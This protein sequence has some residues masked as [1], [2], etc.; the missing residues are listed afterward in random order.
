FVSQREPK[1]G[2]RVRHN[3]S[4]PLPARRLCVNGQPEEIIKPKSRPTEIQ[5]EVRPREP[6]KR[7]LEASALGP[8]AAFVLVPPCGR[9]ANNGRS[10]LSRRVLFLG[11]ILSLRDTCGHHR[12]LALRCVNP[13]M[14]ASCVR[15]SEFW[16]S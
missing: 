2:Q 16:G 6:I 15:S 5:T 3:Q 12:F 4:R 9:S 14:R 1:R 13:I 8:K 10:L 7:R 11:F